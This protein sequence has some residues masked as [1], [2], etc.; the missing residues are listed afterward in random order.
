MTLPFAEAHVSAQLDWNDLD[1][2]LEARVIAAA[3]KARKALQGKLDKWNLSAA[4]KLKADT[5]GFL[6]AVRTHL[7]GLDLAVDVKVRTSDASLKAWS[8]QLQ[9]RID[10]KR[11]TVNVKP[12]PDVARFPTEM[13]QRLRQM[14]KLFG[15]EISVRAVP[16]VARF[17]KDLQR[18]LREM[19]KLFDFK[20]PVRVELNLAAARADLQRFLRERSMQV[21]LEIT[22]LDRLKNLKIPDLGSMAGEVFKVASQMAVLVGAAG[23]AAGAVAVLGV[24]LLSLG[25]AALAGVATLTVGLSGV[26]DAFSAL[27]AAQDSAGTD[28]QAQ[29]TATKAASDQVVSA[30]RSVRDAKKDSTQAEKDLTTA[31]KDAQKQMRDLNLEVRGGV[32][33]EREAQLDLSDARRD[34][35]SAKPGEEYERAQLAIAKAEQSLTEVRYRNNDLAEKQQD[36]LAKGVEGSDLVVAAQDKVAAAHEKVDDTTKALTDAQEA[37]TAAQTKSS[38]AQDKAAQALAKLAP[39]ARDFVVAARSIGPAWDSL[40][41]QPT[42]NALFAGAADGIKDLA[43]VA[44]PV[45]GQGMTGVATQINSV[46][47]DFANF[48]KAPENLGAVKTIF[49]GAATFIGALSPGLQQA[50]QGFLSLGQAFTPVAATVGKGVGDLL[51]QVGQA[52]TTAFQSGALTELIGNFGNL[53]SG[54]GAGL[55]PLIGGLIQIGNIVGPTLGPLFATLGQSI[56]QIAPGLGQIGAVFAQTLTTLIPQ[57]VPIINTLTSALTPILP[58]IGQIASALLSAIGPAIGPLSQV[59]Q[60]VGGALAQAITALAPSIGPLA[61]AFASMVGAFAPIIP[62]VAQVVSGL[63]AALAPALTTIFGALGPV[64][65]QVADLMMPIF[66]QLQPILAQVAEQLGTAIAS[67]LQQLAPMLPGLAAS[68]GGLIAAIAP[69]L[70]QLLQ[71]ALQLLP[72]FL[73]IV[74]AIL[75]QIEKMIDV[76]TWL[77]TN[78]IVPLVIPQI[79]RL[80]KTLGDQ[81]DNAAAIITTV[82]DVFWGALGKIGEFFT[83]L[84]STVSDVFS[85]IRGAIKAAAREIG[86]FLIGLPEIKIPDLPGIPGRGT[87]VGFAGIGRAMVNWAGA[88]GKATGGRLIRG[89]GTGTSDSIPALMDGIKPLRVANGE[90]ISTAQAYANGG[91]LLQALNAGWIPSPE[92]LHMLTGTAPGFSGG[93]LVTP[94]QL[95]GFAKGVEGAPYNWGGIHWGDCSAAVS[96]LANYATGKEPFGSRFSTGTMS[97]A[98]TA[99]GAQPGLGPSGSL[100]FGWFNDGPYGGHTAATLPNG[101]KFEMGGKRGDGQYGGQAAGAND[102]EFSDHMHFPPEF[103]LGG[104][105]K[106]VGGGGASTTTGGG[107][108]TAG[109]SSATQSATTGGTGAPVIGATGEPA[110]PDLNI[111]STPGTGIDAANTWAAGQDFPGKFQTWGV[112][113]LKS[114]VGEFSDMFGLKSL[115]DKGIDNGVEAIKN[116]K[117]ADTMNF[118][119]MDPQKVADETSKMLNRLSPISETYRAG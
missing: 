116:L 11:F 70:P 109:T 57:L 94:E 84:G 54:L 90:F 85:T 71:M 61:D 2:Q 17:P 105:P 77:V 76:F 62:V 115:T 28:A 14:S 113:A 68:F 8:D 32:I 1:A 3:E 24:G 97:Q 5:A 13:L 108:W 21:R 27:S 64:I 56:G 26:K 59:A 50:T 4:V 111:Q 75:P 67:A 65:S 107:S 36:S 58:V 31:R 82:R 118:Y 112:D 86:N 10:K 49:D 89:P 12:V 117:L 45:L 55:N 33:S 110:I 7:K 41:K 98:L 18:A 103:F 102:P 87:T 25:P 66:Q 20:I 37:L 79:E 46:T 6:T 53:L 83:G 78:V 88:E 96:A 80:T 15:F 93:G 60:I 119:G 42:Q 69:L 35:L 73:D 91:P 43:T 38:G 22:G 39:N 48:W 81:M 29:A 106:S 95:E 100:S 101:T 34:A 72:P 99:M 47:K 30:E 63:V 9:L 16:D 114:V 92:F 23:A 19:S 40:V 104:D 51:G 74:I 52:F 44:L